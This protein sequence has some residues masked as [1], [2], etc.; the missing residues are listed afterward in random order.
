MDVDQAL[1]EL[2]HPYAVAIRL[3][4]AGRPESDI[5]LALGI[6]DDAVPMVLRLGRDKL[7]SLLR[8]SESPPFGSR[9]PDSAIADDR[10]DEP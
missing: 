1:T 9:S 4:E 5:A 2:P 7:A 3:H 6:A 8:P 10:G